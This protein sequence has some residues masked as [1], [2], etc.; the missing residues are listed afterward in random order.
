MNR[1]QHTGSYGLDGN[2]DSRRY[3]PPEKTDWASRLG[4]RMLDLGCTLSTA[5]S[6]TGGYLAHRLTAVPGSSGYYKGSVIAYSNEIKIKV[7]SVPPAVLEKEGAVSEAV[8][9]AMAQNVKRLMDTDYAIATSGIAG[10]G[11]GTPQKPV[12]TVWMAIA[13]P[14]GCLSQLFHLSSCRE[15][16]IV[17]STYHALR[18]LSEIIGIAD[19]TD[20]K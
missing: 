16:N 3:P 14:G 17:L 2:P 8:V 6:C 9:R 11:G 4:A 19:M 20:K 13:T 7:L 18:W 1:I 12:G 10:P 5:E 15:Q